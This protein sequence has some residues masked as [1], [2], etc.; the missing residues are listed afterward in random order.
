MSRAT[1]AFAALVDALEAETPPCR[2]DLRYLADQLSIK[3]MGE[4]QLLCSTCPAFRLCRAYALAE[5]P[6]SGVWAGERW[7]EKK[8]PGRP[9]K[10]HH[11]TT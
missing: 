4:I 8:R 6:S 2:G 9:R 11:G 7:I 10:D 5:R 1:D 3:D